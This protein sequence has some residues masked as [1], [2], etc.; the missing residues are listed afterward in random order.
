MLSFQFM[1]SYADMRYENLIISCI[2]IVQVMLEMASPAPT[3]ESVTSITVDVTPGLHAKKTL[4]R[5]AAVNPI[6][7]GI[8]IC[9]FILKNILEIKVLVN[10]LSEKTIS[11]GN[12]L[13]SFEIAERMYSKICVLIVL[14][15]HN[16]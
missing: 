5:S 6:P 7:I 14:A 1:F 10:L 15:L 12:L 2:F 8:I 9:M 16:T 4:V 3:S 11:F 13:L